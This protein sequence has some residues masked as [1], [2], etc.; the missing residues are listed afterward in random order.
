MEFRLSNESYKL[1]AEQNIT[2]TK[3]YIQYDSIYKSQNSKTWTE[4]IKKSS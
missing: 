3:E 2:D 1:K 4:A